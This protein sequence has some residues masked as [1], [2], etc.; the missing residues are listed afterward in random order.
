[1]R[2]VNLL[3]AAGGRIN[4]DTICGAVYTHNSATGNH[5][6]SETLPDD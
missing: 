5:A 1:M 2:G 6:P 4:P 3:D